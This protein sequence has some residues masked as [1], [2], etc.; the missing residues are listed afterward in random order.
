MDYIKFAPLANALCSSNRSV[1]SSTTISKSEIK[2]I[3]TL[4][5]SDRECELIRYSVFK[6][7]GISY[8]AAKHIFGFQDMKSS[9][10]R[11][12]NSIKESRAICEAVDDLAHTSDM[13][14]LSSMGIDVSLS[15]SLNQNLNQIRLQNRM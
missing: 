9:E 15:L 10:T 2:S 5:Q 14:L 3:M 6:V 7:S 11:I 1:R 4:A 13:A 12:L 8:T